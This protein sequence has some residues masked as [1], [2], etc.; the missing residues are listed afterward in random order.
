MQ[1]A[2]LDKY[3]KAEYNHINKCN[4]K[5]TIKQHPNVYSSHVDVEVK[6]NKQKYPTRTVK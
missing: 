4:T 2:A 5:S 3:Q 1:E 6:K